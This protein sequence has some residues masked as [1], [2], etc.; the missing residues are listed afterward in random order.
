MKKKK[1]TNKK[2]IQEVKPY[3]RQRHIPWNNKPLNLTSSETDA[4]SKVWFS[5]LSFHSTILFSSWRKCIFSFQNMPWTHTFLSVM[6]LGWLPFSVCRWW[7]H[8]FPMNYSLFHLIKAVKYIIFLSS[9]RS[10]S[11]FPLDCF[12]RKMKSFPWGMQIRLS[13]SSIQSKVP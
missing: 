13:A 5:T 12:L 9:N 11:F 10:G 1:I 3:V 2:T 6:V 8:S 7:E 4:A